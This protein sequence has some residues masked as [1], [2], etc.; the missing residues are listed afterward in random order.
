MKILNFYAHSLEG[1]P[2]RDWQLL[3][4]HLSQV[5]NKA[6]EFA[7]SWGGSEWAYLAGLWHDL[8]KYSIEFQNKLLVENGFEAHLE[9]ALGKVVHS[10]AGGHLSSINGWKGIDRVLSWL[11]MGHH[12]GLTDFNSDIIGAK[13]LSPKMK[14][15]QRSRKILENIPVSILKKNKPKT[16]FP[17]GSDAAFFIRM[18]FSCLVDADFLDTEEFM[19]KKRSKLRQRE[20]PSLDNLLK[21]F[22]IYIKQLCEKAK[23]SELNQIRK[24]VLEQCYQAADDKL[25]VFSLTVPTGG[26]KT[27]SS[28]A[29]ALKH[30]VKNKKNRIIYVIPYTSIIEQTAK[31]FREI[32]GFEKAVLEHHSNI[33]EN[34]EKKESAC[35]RLSA[36]NWDAPI[37]V[38]T[39][40]QFFESLY[41]CKTS[42]CRKLHNITN[43]VIIFDEIQCLPTDYLRPCVFAIRELFDYYNV[44]PVLCTATQPVITEIKNFDFHFKEGFVNVKE[45]ISDKKL[46]F[47]SL[48]RVKLEILKNDFSSVSNKKL[49]KLLLNECQSVLCILNRKEDCRKLARLLPD[50]TT[51]HLSTNMC[52]QHRL[53]EFKKARKALS[54]HQKIYLI[55]TSLVEAGVDIDFPVVY[56]ALT[57]LD[58][59]VHAAGRCNRE[60]KMAEMGRTIVFMPEKQPNYVK[61][62]AQIAKEFLKNT[63]LEEIFFPD[64]FDKYFRQRYWQLGAEQL[65]KKGILSKLSGRMDFYYRTAAQEFQFIEN[66][67]QFPVIAPYGEAQEIINHLISCPWE[68]RNDFRKL[69]RFTVNIEKKYMKLLC[70][71]GCAYSI[72]Q[73]PELFILNNTVYDKRFGFIPAEEWGAS[74][75]NNFMC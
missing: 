24:N 20:Y 50:N 70:D 17:K 1:K 48:Q 3:E 7:N 18:I 6:A 35:S 41:A 69:Q 19:D 26:G 15:Y 11:I 9:C 73:F 31:V 25:K 2:M 8:G 32:P 4:Q 12:A 38:T 33:I 44:T 64:N 67:W 22:D 62:Q 45:I 60:G 52:A 66:D 56:R 36:E 68:Q 40:V 43:S 42:S 46:L 27:L 16:P 29:F 75:P 34:G 61:Q 39:S 57:G 55:S 54:R 23:K 49:S 21:Y 28:M 30:A 63:A 51:I 72:K 37:I 74:D 47:Q 58:S 14:N 10:E 13:A 65:D 59:I 71:K 5:A 53:N